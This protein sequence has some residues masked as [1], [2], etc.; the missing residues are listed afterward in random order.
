MEGCDARL[1]LLVQVLREQRSS[2]RSSACDMH[3]RHHSSTSGDSTLPRADLSTADE[4]HAA[5]A[6]AV[7]VQRLVGGCNNRWMVG[8]A[9]II[10]GTCR[11]GRVRCV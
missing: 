2:K 1:Q 5:Q 10:V 8:E 4:A 11:Q 3:A 7:R 9:Q 6:K